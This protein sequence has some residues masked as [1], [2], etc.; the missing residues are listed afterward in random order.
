MTKC[1]FIHT[2]IFIWQISYYTHTNIQTNICFYIHISMLF[3]LQ[4]VFMHTLM[5]QCFLIFYAHTTIMIF[6]YTYY[7]IFFTLPCRHSIYVCFISREPLR[8]IEVWASRVILDSY[9]AV[10]HPVTYGND[11]FLAQACKT[12]VSAGNT[13]KITNQQAFLLI[14][15]TVY[16]FYKDIRFSW[17]TVDFAISAV[18]HTKSVIMYIKTIIW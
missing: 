1:D 16:H 14:V 9:T 11:G 12:S 6:F 10:I 7:Y 8:F 15:P 2:N 3:A 4:A 13:H 17:Q 18:I 5:Y